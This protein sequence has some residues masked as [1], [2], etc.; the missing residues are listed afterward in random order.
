MRPGRLFQQHGTVSILYNPAASG[1]GGTK[2]ENPTTFA[3]LALCPGPVIVHELSQLTAYML[4]NT[5]SDLNAVRTNQRGTYALGRDIDATAIANFAPIG[6]CGP[7]PALSVRPAASPLT[8]RREQSAAARPRS[9]A[10]A[11]P[12]S[13]STRRPAARS[14]TWHTFKCAPLPQSPPTALQGLAV[15]R[16]HKSTIP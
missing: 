9:R 11:V 16:A 4:V 12:R 5:A 1:A 7:P 3:C 6:T 10:R 14:S 8:H 2:Y 15:Q 13:P